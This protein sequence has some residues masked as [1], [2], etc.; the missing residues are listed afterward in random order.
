[1]VSPMSKG[2]FNKAIAQSGGMFSKQ[3]QSGNSLKESE[4]QGMEWSRKLGIKSLKE[5]RQIPADSLLKISG[6]FGITIDNVVIPPVAEAFAQNKHH[7]VPLISGWNA[8]DGVRFGAPD[9]ADTYKKQIVNNYGELASEYLK[10]FPAGTDDEAANSQKLETQLM[11]GWNNYMWAKLQNRPSYLYY[12]T[13]VPP[14]EPNY[15]AFHSAEFGYALH[16]LKHWN[17]PFTENDFNL[18]QIMSSYWVN[19]AKNGNPNGPGLPEWPIFN[20]SLP[21]VIQLGDE[22]KTIGLPYEKQLRFISSLNGHK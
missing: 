14:G 1:M 18:E 2:L 9:K 17:R 19:F 21:Q 4:T 11:F 15:G 3:S 5:M 20:D 13:K 6:R 7:N 12:F 10:Y 8:D 16:T 22:V